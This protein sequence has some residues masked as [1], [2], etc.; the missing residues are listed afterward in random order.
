MMG[1]IRRPVVAGVVAVLLVAALAGCSKSRIAR[2]V[3][4]M[5]TSNIQRL[6]NLYSAFQN[7]HGG[8]G[9]RN[10][11]EFKKFVKEFDP[12]KLS[13]MGINPG[14]LE[15]VFVSE[16]DGLPFTVRYKVAGG[17]GAVD[18]VVFEQKG[19]DTLREVGFTGGAVEEEDNVHYEQFLTGKAPSTPPGAAPK[20]AATGRS[21]RP[22]GPPPGAPTGPTS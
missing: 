13:M 12:T 16:R 1:T 6:S 7:T 5:N 18:A 21:R 3:S 17:R 19:Q 4:A 22:H 2:E 11:M 15:A 10:D 20:A 9:P 14:Q 8:R